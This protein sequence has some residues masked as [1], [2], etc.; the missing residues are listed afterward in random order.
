MEKDFLTLIDSLGSL[1]GLQSLRI[2]SIEPTTI[3]LEL[4]GMMKDS[5]H[6][7]MPYL[8]VPMQSGCNKI[9]V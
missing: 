2:S 8:H 3:P 1:D 4:F 6:P 9:L 7:L 5:Q